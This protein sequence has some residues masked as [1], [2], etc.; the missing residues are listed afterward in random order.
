[1]AHCSGMLP[2]VDDIALYVANSSV[3]ELVSCKVAGMLLGRIEHVA[4]E[5]R[6]DGHM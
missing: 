6:A 2:Y 1:M 3:M 4:D 5:S